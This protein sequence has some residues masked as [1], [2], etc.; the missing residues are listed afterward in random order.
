M[1]VS[2]NLFWE[3]RRLKKLI[4]TCVWACMYSYLFKITVNNLL[5]IIRHTHQHMHT[6][7]VNTF[8]GIV[9]QRRRKGAR[10]G[11][12]QEQGKNTQD[13]HKHYMPN[14]YKNIFSVFCI[15]SSHDIQRTYRFDDFASRIP[16]H[17]Q[18]GYMGIDRCE[19]TYC[20]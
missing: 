11:A 9:A 3:C 20:A 15:S 17:F 7:C 14:T 4:L 16:T 8:L 18:T 12:L 10:L 19:S 13:H 1:C 2:V 5:C 6:P